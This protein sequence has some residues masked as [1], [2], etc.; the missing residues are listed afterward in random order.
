M[1]KLINEKSPYL[2][3]HAKNPIN[4]YPWSDEPFIKAKNEDKPIFLSIG[5]STCHWCHVMDL[6]SFNEKDVADKMNNTF[7][8][9]KVDREERPDIDNL[10]MTMSQ[11]MTGQ[12]GWPLNVIL[13]PDKKPVFSFTYIPKTSRNNNIGLMDLCDTVNYFWKNKRPE[14][15]KNGDTVIDAITH[16]NVKRKN[17][18]INYESLI[19]STFKSLKGNYDEEYGGFGNAPKF[20]SF[21]H[22]IF[23]LDYY[24]NYNDKKALEMAEK[25]MKTMRLGGVYDQIGYGFHRYSTDA[26]WRIP[27]FEKMAYDQAMA[28]MAYTYM[29]SI[30]K[31]DFYKNVVYEIFQF[32]KSEMFG[33]AFYTAVDADSENEEGRYY[34]WA[35]DEISHIVDSEFI[36]SFDVSKTGNFYD[37]NYRLTGR[38][39]LY[40][41]GNPEEIHGKKM[42]LNIKKLY[43]TRNKRKGHLIDD[44]ILVDINGLTIKALAISSMVFSD[45]NMLEYAEK[46]ADFIISKMYKNNILYHRYREGDVSI[47]GF[48]DDYAFFSSGLLY[49]YEASFN[50]MYLKYFEE[51]THEMVKKFYDSEYGGFYETDHPEVVKLKESY[52]NAIP[53]GFSIAID[54][55]VTYRYLN[56]K[57]DTIVDA[58]LNSVYEEMT[59][60]PM[61][62]SATVDAFFKKLRFYKIEAG[63]ETL[64]SVKKYY[65]N[66]YFV[67]SSNDGKIS[68]CD[69]NKCFIVEDTKKLVKIIND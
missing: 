19:K 58:S 39:I 32:L 64:D 50:D 36:K 16:N 51:I 5:Y 24:K 23:L 55:L 67:I 28:I 9:I 4:W 62:F 37:N 3:E 31:N 46:A 1:N 12:G 29:Y 65:P 57:Y 8:C 30:T 56:N 11:I 69:I 26:L 41:S 60:K 68:V 38:N 43:E 59:S 66:N 25:T 35:Y 52:D 17:E 44:K 2:L 40:F 61:F 6:E 54:N 21:Q 22:I 45:K 53:S 47:E 49:L 10:Y 63:K 15:E 34:T 20:P 7:I 33:N 27:H 14:L 42:D 18:E 48:L 13:T